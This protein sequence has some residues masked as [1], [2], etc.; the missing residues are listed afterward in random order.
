M[1]DDP[2]WIAADGTEWTAE[3]LGEQCESHATPSGSCSHPAEYV[4]VRG[5]VR[6]QLCAV[7][8][9]KIEPDCCPVWDE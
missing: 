6:I 8:F 2:V 3:A 9:A 1:R 4:G 5:D 7:H